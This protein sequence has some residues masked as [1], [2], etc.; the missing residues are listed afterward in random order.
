M[1]RAPNVFARDV[2]WGGSACFKDRHRLRI[3]ERTSGAGQGCRARCEARQGGRARRRRRARTRTCA[4][5]GEHKLGTAAAGLSSVNVSPNPGAVRV[6]RSMPKIRTLTTACFCA[7]HACRGPGVLNICA[8]QYPWPSLARNEPRKWPQTLRHPQRPHWRR[9][10]SAS[11]LNSCTRKQENRWFPL[12]T[13]RL[14]V[15]LS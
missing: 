6:G 15:L 12:P 2:R 5:R 10:Q 9:A 13:K 8:P 11:S 7:P 3:H 4:R 14:R 1:A